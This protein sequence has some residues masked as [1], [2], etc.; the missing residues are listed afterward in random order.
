MKVRSFKE[1]YE[2]LKDIEF[3]KTNEN[4]VTGEEYENWVK[5]RFRNLTDEEEKR[6]T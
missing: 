5:E 1:L 6:L 4:V 2:D 3:K